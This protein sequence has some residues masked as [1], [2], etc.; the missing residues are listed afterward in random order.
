MSVFIGRDRN[1]GA[2]IASP[3][4]QPAYHFDWPRDGAFFDLALD[5]AGFSEV[6]NQHLDFYRRTQQKKRFSVSFIRL[7]GLKSPF[8]SPRG[9]WYS[10]LYTNG[11][12]GNLSV[13]PYEIDETALLVWDLWRHEQ[14][15]KETDLSTYQSDFL[16]MLQLG[17]NA[18]NMFVKKNKGWIRRGFEDDNF[19]P[20]ATL[21]GAA[22]ILA[23]LASAT[24]AG[25]RWGIAPK[26]V[27]QWKTSA[28]ALRDGILDK[29]ENTP[30]LKKSGWRGIQWLL[31]PAPCP[32]PA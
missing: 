2:I 3:S 25:Q 4:R 19:I 15:V 21:H 5:L 26:Q 24:D 32:V 14:F 8:Y 23:G 6:V 29:I 11:R 22:A 17:A 28:I 12:K 10:N 31:F 30:I 18:I 20:H 13:I 16:E 7:L 9:H 27:T 1:S